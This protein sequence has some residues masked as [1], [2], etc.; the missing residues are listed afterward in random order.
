HRTNRV[1][2]VYEAVRRHGVGAEIAALIQELA[3]DDLDAP[4]LRVAGKETT[5][6]L[7]PVLEQAAIPSE[8]DLSQAIRQV[9]YAVA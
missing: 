7:S 2:V 8:E 9:L 6:A 4:V 1:V 3:F 5:L